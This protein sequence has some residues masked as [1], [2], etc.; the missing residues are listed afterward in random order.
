MTKIHENELHLEHL[1]VGVWLTFSFSRTRCSEDSLS[2]LLGVEPERQGMGGGESCAQSPVV[3]LTCKRGLG[4][5]TQ[6][7]LHVTSQLPHRKRG[8]PSV[9]F[10][11]ALPF[12]GLPLEM[13]IALMPALEDSTLNTEQRRCVPESGTDFMSAW[14]WGLCFWRR[15]GRALEE[16]RPVWQAVAAL[17]STSVCPHVLWLSSSLACT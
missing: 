1:N 8:E 5:V 15:G 7:A 10:P 9:S 4:L 11:S 12:L 3:S 17:G 6:L 14:S 13:S 2:S 16:P